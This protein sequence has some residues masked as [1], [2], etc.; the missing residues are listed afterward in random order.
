M[1]NTQASPDSKDFTTIPPSILERLDPEYRDFVLS[2]PPA[3]RTP[4]HTIG[5]SEELCEKINSSTAGKTDPVPVGSTHT[6]DLNGFTAGV[7]TPDGSPPD[8]GWPAFIYVHGGGF[9]FGNIGT[10]AQFYTRLCVEARCIVVSVGYRLAPKHTFPAAL[11][12]T[13]STL[14]W[15]FGEGGVKFGIN[16]ERVAIGGYSAGANLA[17]AIA[18]RAVLS[19][20]PY[21]LLKQVLLAPPLDLTPTTD[22]ATWSA[23]MRENADVVGLYALDVL[24]SRDINTPNVEDRTNPEVSPLLQTDERAFKGLAPAWI[25]VSEL[26]VL[27]SDGENYARKLQD[28]GVPVELKLYKG[29]NHLTAQADKV[30]ELARTIQNDRIRAI[31]AAFD[32]SR[33]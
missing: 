12:D 27:R 6:V 14:L 32:S 7:F 10:G 28:Y 17:A 29:A 13:W 33:L 24:W 20:L 21:R 9:L 31:V 22:P 2:H 15:V 8:G 4:L 25:G 18:Q 1:A 26:D 30:C 11:D 5:W 19:Q 16:K 3:S 23:S